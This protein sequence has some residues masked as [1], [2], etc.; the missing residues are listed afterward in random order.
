LIK[1]EHSKIWKL[2]NYYLIK[3]WIFFIKQNEI[4]HKE[5]D[6]INLRTNFY[7]KNKK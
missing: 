6:V 5:S 2:I 1:K 3:F 7:K 4:K